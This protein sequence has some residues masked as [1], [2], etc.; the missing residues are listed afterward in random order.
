MGLVEAKIRFCFQL[1]E[2]TREFAKFN[3]L[4]AEFLYNL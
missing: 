1:K 2:E 3:Y 4:E